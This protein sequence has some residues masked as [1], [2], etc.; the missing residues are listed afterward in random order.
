MNMFQADRQ[1]FYRTLLDNVL[2]FS[3]GYRPMGTLVYR[4]L[5]WLF[6]LSALPY[7]VVCYGL[8]LGNLYI[9]YLAARSIATKEAAIL[10]ALILSY[11][12]AFVDLYY[13]FGTIYDLLC[14]SFYFSALGFYAHIRK[15][16]SYLHPRALTCLLF[17]Y[18]CALN[19]KEMAVTLPV[20]LILYEVTLERFVPSWPRWKPAVFC[21]LMTLPY[22]L[23]KLSAGSPL[24][25]NDAYRLHLGVRTYLR[26]MGHYLELLAYLSPGAL[27]LS[28]AVITL[29][30]LALVVLIA[31]QRSLL[32]LWLF[33]LL[34]PLPIAFVGQRTAY[35]MYIPSFGIAVFLA[36][37]AVRLR[38]EFA[39]H[40]ANAGTISAGTARVL[41]ADTF[42]L[43][44]IALIA[45]HMS[46]PLPGM[47]YTEKW[48]QSTLAQ[49]PALQRA[50]PNNSRVVFLDDPF[51][52][53]GYD[54][55]Y[56]V[57]LLYRASDLVVDRAKVMSPKPSPE[58]V[59]SYDYVFALAGDRWILQPKTSG[60]QNP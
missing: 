19:S 32:F 44:L 2:Y 53:D 10:A 23:G 43:C 46:K 30:G 27:G 55:L 34:T 57:S 33:I 26:A 29:L 45:F 4:A 25:G 17:L 1:P 48:I 18:V 39:L 9:L 3:A 12:T 50:V 21:T 15:S 22:M 20:I 47:G 49:L 60:P 13:N 7:R 5:Y 14:F 41:K 16:G 51:S 38:R 37:V 24:T 40:I 8:I 11:N 54:L 35:A 42:V 59:N 31:R 58:Q 6:G 28:G 36:E 52:S 56:I